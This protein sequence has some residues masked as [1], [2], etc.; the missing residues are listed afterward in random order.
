MTPVY[1]THFRREDEPEQH[2]KG[3]FGGLVRTT[4]A[5]A[6]S[7]TAGD[8]KG[9][10]ADPSKASARFDDLEAER[11]PFGASRSPSAIVSSPRN[12]HFRQTSR[13]SASLGSAYGGSGGRPF[14]PDGALAEGQATVPKDAIMIELLSGQAAIEAK[15][16]EVLDWERVQEVKKVRLSRTRKSFYVKE[17]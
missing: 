11:L 9:S 7:S 16:Y 14:S 5:T 15:D 17:C 2:K 3:W 13:S 8:A 12:G 6:S 4:S 1:E 10:G